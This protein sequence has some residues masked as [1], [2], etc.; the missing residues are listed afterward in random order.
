MILFLGFSRTVLDLVWSTM[1]FGN[2]PPWTCEGVREFYNLASRSIGANGQSGKHNV[3]YRVDF[4]V[5]LAWMN[6]LLVICTLFLDQKTSHLV[7]CREM[8]RKIAGIRSDCPWCRSQLKMFV[9]WKIDGKLKLLAKGNKAMQEIGSGDWGAV[10]SV[11]QK[12]NRF[13]CNPH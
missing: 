1:E 4:R 10:P 13:H 9:C 3:A 11:E 8:R 6:E 5:R 12:E 2:N 7:K